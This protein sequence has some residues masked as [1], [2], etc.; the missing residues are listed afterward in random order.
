MKRKFTAFFLL[1]CLVL[2]P[3]AVYTYLKVQKRQVRKEV[4]KQIISG[5]SKSELVLLSFSKQELTKVLRWKHSK[6]FAYK[7]MMFDIVESRSTA[8]S[9]FYWC[10]PDHKESRLNKNLKEL[11]RLALNKN[12]QRND[13]KQRLSRFLNS[14]YFEEPA[15]WHSVNFA[16]MTFYPRFVVSEYPGFV[17]PPLPPPPKRG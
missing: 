14:F 1:V 6:E 2:P 4:K 7:D 8:D 17:T 15:S 11:A 10:W 16:A 9:V 3:V 5:I 13:Q 12:P